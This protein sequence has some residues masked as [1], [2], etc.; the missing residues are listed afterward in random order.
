MYSWTNLSTHASQRQP[1][2]EIHTSGLKKIQLRW[3][4]HKMDLTFPTWFKL[5]NYLKR[6]SFWLLYSTLRMP[7]RWSNFTVS[8]HLCSEFLT[9]AIKND[10]NIEGIQI[11]T[12]EHKSSQYADDTSVYLKAS[13]RNLRNCLNTLEWFYYISGLK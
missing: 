3:K 9:L 4:F 2:M 7:P 6:S 11:L 1:F 5:E 13:V 8:F 10:E 12:K